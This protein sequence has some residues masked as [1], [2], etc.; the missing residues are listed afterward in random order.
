MGL[1]LSQRSKMSLDGGLS[2]DFEWHFDIYSMF[3]KTYQIYCDTILYIVNREKLFLSQITD[4]RLPAE[5]FFIWMVNK[6]DAI[7]YTD[8][9]CVA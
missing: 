5:S 7:P 8:V 6:G 4:L 2:C 3:H 9:F 1:A